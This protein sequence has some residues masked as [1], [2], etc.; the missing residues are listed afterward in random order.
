MKMNPE[1]IICDCD[2]KDVN[3]EKAVFD[4][5]GVDFKWLHCQTQEEVI[6]Q[7]QGA[8][9]FLNQYTRMDEKIFKAIPTLK[10]IVRYGVGVDNVNLSDANKYHVQVCNVPDYGTNEVADH[11]LALM[12]SVARKTYLAGNLT[13]NGVWDYIKTVPI[14]RLS[15]CTVGIISMGRI[16]SAFAARVHALGCRV[17][18]YNARKSKS[19]RKYPDYV[20][21]LDSKE[22]VLRQADFLSLH[23]A[24]TEN[25]RGMMNADAFAQMKD[26]AILIN[27]ARGGLVDENAL[28]SALASGKLAGA[29][30][31]VVCEEPL[32]KDSPLFQHPNVVVTPH[33][34]WYSEES[35]LELN[36][37]CAEEAVRFLSGQ[38]VHYPVNHFEE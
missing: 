35:A 2:H 34:G 4:A 22:D 12:L 27:T 3:V 17:V 6:E 8:V 28:A 21:F 16:G 11:A 26:G 24:L 14:H 18:T 7:C 9:C 5:A 36:R 19:N 10:F 32:S 25:N 31:D 13:R 23:C 38:Q 1:I 20:E 29:G 33:M 15:A 37:K 30:I